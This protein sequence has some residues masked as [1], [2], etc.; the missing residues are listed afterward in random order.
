M[1]LT[2]VRHM[3]TDWNAEGRFTSQAFHLRLNATGIAQAEAMAARLEQFPFETVY[4]SDQIRALETAT[5]IAARHPRIKAFLTDAR[6]REVNAG[7]CVG[8]VS[9]EVTEP[10]F[11]TRHPSFDYRSIGGEC[12]ADVIARQKSFLADI[13]KNDGR[14][15]CLVVGHGTALRVL[16]VEMGVAEVLTRENFIRMKSDYKEKENDYLRIHQ[17]E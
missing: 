13:R 8:K 1:I 2:F 12:R 15:E 14:G 11:Q 9:S 5:I 7:S 3:E 6:L 4:S 10:I 16:L 17:P